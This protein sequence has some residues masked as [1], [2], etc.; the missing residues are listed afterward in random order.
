MPFAG[1][2]KTDLDLKIAVA[3]KLPG[4]GYYNVE[5]E[6]LPTVAPTLSKMKK[7]L[8]SDYTQNF[9]KSFKFPSNILALID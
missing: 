5:P 4:V 9:D 1:R 2:G 6:A 8:E 7:M 3:S